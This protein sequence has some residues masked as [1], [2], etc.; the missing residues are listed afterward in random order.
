M[1]ADAAGN[2]KG[3]GGLVSYLTWAA[4]KQATSF[5]PLL[6]RLLPHEV[7][8]KQTSTTEITYRTVDEIREELIR[9]GVPL[10][11]IAVELHALASKTNEDPDEP[12]PK[13]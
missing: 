10:D 11:T 6:G 9:R 7:E 4:T 8:A 5:I 2:K 3:R 1:A 12:A 13:K